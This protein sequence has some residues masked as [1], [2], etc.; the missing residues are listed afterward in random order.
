MNIA[1]TVLILTLVY[2][3][4]LFTLTHIPPAQTPEM[5]SADKLLHL[6]AY[7]L[8]AF[9]V[10]LNLLLTKRWNRFSI[11]LSMIALTV[12]AGFDEL[13]QLLV[14]RT[15]AW[16]DWEADLIGILAGTTACAMLIHIFRRTP[17]VQ[18]L[19]QPKT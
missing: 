18:S 8:L 15:A 5:G 7:T 2:W 6:V 1:K 14:G 11:L 16:Y 3:G 19:L 12:Y 13:T 9:L 10:S 4:I 17:L